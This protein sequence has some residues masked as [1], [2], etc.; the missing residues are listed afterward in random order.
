MYTEYNRIKS[1]LEAPRGDPLCIVI[2][3]FMPI[4]TGT[5]VCI[6]LYIPTP[7]LYIPILSNASLDDWSLSF[8]AR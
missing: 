4:L 6:Y 7:I 3:N 2:C 8:D 1:S 5:Q